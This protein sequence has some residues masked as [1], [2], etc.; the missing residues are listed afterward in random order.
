[1]VKDFTSSN[2][3][4]SRMINPAETE[5][6]KYKYSKWAVRS[7]NQKGLTE[8]RIF[9][10]V[11][12]GTVVPQYVGL[13]KVK[14]N[15]Q[16]YISD[17]LMLAEACVCWGEGNCTFLSPKP[18]TLRR[19]G[20][21]SSPAHM[22]YWALWEMREKRPAETPAF[23]HALF[24][25]ERGKGTPMQK[26]RPV[27]FMQGVLVQHAG[28]PTKDR[29][30]NPRPWYPV[31]LQVNQ[32]TAQKELLGKLSTPLDKA[33]PLSG[34]NNQI[35]N[36]LGLDGH[37]LQII[38]RMVKTQT[39]DQTHYFC[40]PGRPFVLTAEQAISCFV[41]WEELLNFPSLEQSIEYIA[42]SIGTEATVLGL[43][44]TPYRALLSADLM[45]KADRLTNPPVAIASAPPVEQ[46][47]LPYLPPVRQMTPAGPP[48]MTLEDA[49]ISDKAAP[50]PPA[51]QIRGPA[52]LPA[53]PPPLTLDAAVSDDNRPDDTDDPENDLQ[54]FAGGS[55]VPDQKTLIAS[56]Q[57]AQ[58]RL[59]K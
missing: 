51:V 19:A 35:G 55:M 53:A 22:L 2:D 54:P 5:D 44:N 29:D 45:A 24:R 18:A 14:D 6:G 9:P 50:L 36:L 59:G 49:V 17:T 21:T 56:L 46:Q 28:Q 52:T 12:D 13:D 11:V 57:K 23:V 40:E 27:L 3:R 32:S 20:F 47:Q 31:L 1:M 16:D 41:P 4:V 25:H 15:P 34:I 30:G 33:K 7:P 58:S 10:Q 38:P 48:A 39:G 8:F 42:G 37:C 43:R 26:P